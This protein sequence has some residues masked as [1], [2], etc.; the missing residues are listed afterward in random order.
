MGQFERYYITVLVNLTQLF[1]CQHANK[2]SDRKNQVFA[3]QIAV[4]SNGAGF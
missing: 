4:S 2:L 3:C 1:V